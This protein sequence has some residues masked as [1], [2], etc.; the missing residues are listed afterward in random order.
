MLF[1]HGAGKVIVGESSWQGLATRKA[2]ERAGTLDALKGTGAEVA[3]F[4]EEEFVK[5]NVGGKYLKH[6][7]LAERAMQADK[8]VYSLCMKTH[9]RADFSLSLKLAFGFTKKSERMAFHVRHLKEKLVDL[10]LVVHPN[11]II[12]DGRK[13]FISGGPFSG[14]VRDANVILAS[15]DRVAMDVES[16]KVIAS[17]ENSKLKD[18]PWSYTQIRRAIA[19]GLGVRSENEYTVVQ[20]SD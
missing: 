8:I 5:V 3:F 11:L 1:E 16:I 10:N 14:Q 18:D 13:C 12:M 19:L 17:Y 15:G 20:D 6:V 2:L 4:D 7:S 9:F